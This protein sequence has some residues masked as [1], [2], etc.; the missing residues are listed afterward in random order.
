MTCLKRLTSP[1]RLAVL[2]CTLG[3]LASGCQTLR[4][5]ASLR[6]VEFGL[7]RV[8][9]TYLA[10]VPLDRI[11]SYE[12]LSALEV[13]KIGTALSREELPLAFTLHLQARNPETNP[14]QAR[15]LSL[16]WTLFLEDRE[17]VSGV[18]NEEVVIPPGQVTDVAIPI[19]LDLLRFFGENVRDLVEL[20]LAVSGQ[21]G[22]A[23][24]EIRLEAVPTIQTPLGPLR[25]PEPITIVSGEVGAE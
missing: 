20:A 11:N 4:E 24:K 17:T 18:L 7:D 19:Q 9:E 16:D 5:V 14:V 8:N 21:E 6:Q 3:V 2:L 22:G 25:Y 23:P 15:L 10:G 12:D 1:L 13:L